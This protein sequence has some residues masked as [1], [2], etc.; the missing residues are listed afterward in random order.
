MARYWYSYVVPNADP[1]LA[2]SYQKITNNGGRP[3]CYQGPI[4]CAIYAPSGGP[5][6]FS[7]LSANLLGY[8]ATALS[9][10]Q[11]QPQE[12]GKLFVYLKST[13]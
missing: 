6:P 8:I 10:L 2:S 4:L 13:V 1:R 12:D 3:G 9:T 7:P 11:P 5:F